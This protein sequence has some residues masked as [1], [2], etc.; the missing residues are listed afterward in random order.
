MI[1]EQIIET[2]LFITKVEGHHEFKNKILDLI[3]EMPDASYEG[4]SK[5][6]W[7]LPLDSTRN[8]LDFFYKHIGRPVMYQLSVFLGAD[9]WKI[10]NGW[11][12]QYNENSS[13]TWHNH[14]GTNF[15]NVYF[16][17]LPDVNDKTQIKYLRT[18][19]L[20]EYEVEEGDLLTFPAHLLH[21]SKPNLGGRKTVISFNSDFIYKNGD[22]QE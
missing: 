10:H 4:V 11:F 8:Y 13:H 7:N 9:N 17:E 18:N 6:D 5:T 21:R 20:T 22:K 2:N 14:I 1:R 16:L 12:Q 15:S 19:S 3:G